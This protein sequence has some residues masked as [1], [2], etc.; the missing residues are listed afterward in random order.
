MGDVMERSGLSKRRRKT[1]WQTFKCL[2]YPTISPRIGD[3]D[4]LLAKEAQELARW[5]FKGGCIVAIFFALPS[6][7][8]HW[9]ARGNEFFDFLKI[10]LGVMGYTVYIERAIVS[11]IRIESYYTGYMDCKGDQ[12]F[13]AR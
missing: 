8:L 6:V 10:V 13:D 7:L 1:L 3:K 12:G 2:F 4:G 11:G 5:W 9:F